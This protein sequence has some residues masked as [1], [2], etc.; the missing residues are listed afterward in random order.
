C[1]PPPRL[2]FAELKEEHRNELHFSLG[3]TVQ[4]TCRPGYAKKPGMSPAVTCLASGEW[5]EALEFCTRKKCSHPEEPVNGRIISLRDL[6]FGSTVVY[7]CEE[8]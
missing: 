2:Y 8:G 7:G 6:L 1:G 5:S 4:Y 3:K